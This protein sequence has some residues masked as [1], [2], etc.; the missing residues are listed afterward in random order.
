MP[1]VRMKASPLITSTAASMLH[2]VACTLLNVLFLPVEIVHDCRLPIVADCSLLGRRVS[3]VTG[4]TSTSVGCFLPSPNRCCR[5]M[6]PAIVPSASPRVV[7]SRSPAMSPDISTYNTDRVLVS[8]F[9]FMSQLRLVLLLHFD[10]LFSLSRPRHNSV[11]HRFHNSCHRRIV[12]HK[13]CFH[14]ALPC[15]NTPQPNVAHSTTTTTV[16]FLCGTLFYCLSV[17]CSNKST[18]STDSSAQRCNRPLAYEYQ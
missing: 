6:A 2:E 15:R 9:W 10:R 4:L 12:E 16:L 14:S 1:R 17:F 13:K 5:S 8:P 11:K 18:N 7:S 3:P